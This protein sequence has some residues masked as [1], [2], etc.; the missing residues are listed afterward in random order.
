MMI[1]AMV[2]VF[3]AA[4]YLSARDYEAD[5]CNPFLVNI[6]VI[7]RVG[8]VHRCAIAIGPSAEARRIVLRVRGGA[9]VALIEVEQEG[10]IVRRAWLTTRER[11]TR[12]MVLGADPMVPTSFI[13]TR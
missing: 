4:A 2:F 5:L 10:R 1:L 12:E 9:D 7:R 6:N 11:P 3:G 13:Q 8:D